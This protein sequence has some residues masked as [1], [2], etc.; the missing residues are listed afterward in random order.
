MRWFDY[1]QVLKNKI[2]VHSVSVFIPCTYH[3]KI[4]RVIFP[5]V[6]PFSTAHGQFCQKLF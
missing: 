6:G 5:L 1:H 2:K 4:N 3:W